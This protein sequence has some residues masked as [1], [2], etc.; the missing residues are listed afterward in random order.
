M[1]METSINN[2]QRN[3]SKKRT[4]KKKTF[5]KRTIV[6]KK[7]KRFVIQNETE[8]DILFS[9]IIYIFECLH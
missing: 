5:S 4:P 2:L 7:D 9:T 6:R 3:E 8:N 1:N